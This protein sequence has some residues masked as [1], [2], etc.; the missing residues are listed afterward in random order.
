MRAAVVTDFAKPP[1]VTDF[2]EPEAAE[3]EVVADIRAAA[4]S[5]LARM[6]ARMP[7]FL[8]A[9][10]PPLVAGLD[11]VAQLPDGRLVYVPVVRSPWGTL[12]ERAAVPLQAARP[13]PEGLGAVQGAAIVNAGTATWLPMQRVLA[14]RV[15]STVVVLGA[16]GAS[17]SV[18]AAI[19]KQLGAERIVAVGRE[20]DKL[21]AVDAD[22][23]VPLDDGF[24]AAMTR[25]GASGVDV[26]LDFLWGTPASEAM[27]ALVQSAPTPMH[28]ID[29]VNVG[30]MAGADIP[31]G[32][33][34]LRS[35]NLHVWG[36]GAGAYTP[37][38]RAE[39]A[40]A[41]L[42]L[43]ARGHISVAVEERPLSD[44]EATWQDPGRLVY[45]P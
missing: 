29:W 18:A 43:A 15:P 1:I 10:E 17:G 2:A 28:R 31:V 40:D 23:I 25:I 42:A 35:A 30:Q 44:L 26:V 37:A 36:S 5:N 33:F 39:A 45:L 14:D 22:E 3:G 21:R 41:I 32:A 20:G 9:Q 24:G 12:A 4:V 6:I 19:A 13:L 7:H 27:Q 34:M 16:T 38:E 8:G 11:G